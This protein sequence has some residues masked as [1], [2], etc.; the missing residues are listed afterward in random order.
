MTGIPGS[1]PDL[2][3]IPTGCAFH[4]RCQFAFEAC[5]KH[6][7]RLEAPGVVGVHIGNQRL[8]TDGTLADGVQSKRRQQCLVACHLYNTE[9]L[10]SH[11]E[12]ALQIMTTEQH[13]N[14]MDNGK[15]DVEFMEMGESQNNE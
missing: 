5:R 8:E 2:R 12:D 1:P 15:G 7:P 6:V 4:L 9:M 14:H 10:G 13:S 11:M 3:H